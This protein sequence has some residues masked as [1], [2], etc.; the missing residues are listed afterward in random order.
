MVEDDIIVV[1]FV[2]RVVRLNETLKS[3]S[4]IFGTFWKL[5]KRV[6]FGLKG[7]FFDGFFE[8]VLV[9]IVRAHNQSGR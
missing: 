5:S 7:H 2:L 9:R 4:L 8:R 6:I 3:V 1:G